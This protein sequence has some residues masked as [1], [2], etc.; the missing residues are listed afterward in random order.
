MKKVTV[1]QL[2]EN[3]YIDAPVYLD[4][5]FI[6]TSPEIPLKPELIQRLKK[7]NYQYVFTDGLPTDSPPAS[8][9]N[10]V[11]SGESLLDQDIK[12]KEANERA[13]QFFDKISKEMEKIFGE[14]REKGDIR[15]ERLI[16]IS[17][18]MMSEV[19]QNKHDLLR[20][21]VPQRDDQLYLVPH[22]VKTAIYALSIADFLKIPPHKQIN[23]ATAALLHE[24]GMLRIPPKIYQH[25]RALSPEERKTIVAHPVI[26][27]KILKEAGFPAT[28]CLGVLEHHEN[29]N[30]SGYP[31]KLS[32]DN[33]SLFGKIIAVASA[34]SA[35]T[36]KRPFRDEHDGHT[37]IMDLVKDGG[38]RYDERI[39][40]ALIFTLSIYP[41]GTYVMLSNGAMGII[42]KT[43]P[44]APKHPLV[45]LLLN[46]HNS[47][48]RDRPVIQPKDGDEVTIERPL[49]KPEV[50]QLKEVLG[51]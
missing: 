40:R 48:Y 17:K 51:R 42:V 23:L 30:G 39:L 47:P 7:W 27:Y 4:E 26:S 36:S 41:I 44:E 28:V 22:A 5:K 18:E 50:E 33:I 16:E 3:S 49:T 38:K 10:V 9:D 43:D 37:S 31:R 32:G 34:Y 15:E 45:R 24:I 46:E 35:A 19:K 2:K 8:T 6:L 11:T 29:V 20:L 21:Q 14:F 12:E 13:R 1:A 25:N